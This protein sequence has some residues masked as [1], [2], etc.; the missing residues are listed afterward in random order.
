MTRSASSGAAGVDEH[1]DL[2]A[3]LLRGR[4]LRELAFQVA[5][6]QVDLADLDLR[7]EDDLLRLGD[8][9]A[10][11]GI[12]LRPVGLRHRAA[13][14]GRRLGRQL[15][16]V[17]DQRLLR[18][19]RFH[20]RAQLRAIV[21]QLLDGILDALAL[22]GRHR[23]VGARHLDAPRVDRADLE[24]A[25]GLALDAD[26]AG[27][28][29]G[30]QVVEQDDVLAPLH[31]HLADARHLG[32]LRIDGD[33]LDLGGALDVCGMRRR[34]NAGAIAPVQSANAWN[35]FSLIRAQP[36]PSAPERTPD[37]GSSGS[38]R[39]CDEADYNSATWSPPV[40][41]HPGSRLRSQ[42]LWQLCR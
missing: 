2:G 11:H 13:V 34:R 38:W 19:G 21:A 42:R 14:G 36:V 32:A 37:Q 7:I 9:L 12:E 31:L 4:D 3:L 18:L 15:R 5:D 33:A 25:R 26:R 24:P 28:G 16:Q 41:L 6:L 20:G 35:R 8:A 17:V 27:H 39:N 22:G 10:D 1:L 30:R 23:F 40:R 29:I